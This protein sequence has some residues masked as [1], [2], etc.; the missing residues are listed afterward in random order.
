MA[1]ILTSDLKRQ[2]QTD[3]LNQIIGNDTD[4]LTSAI[5]TAESELKSYLIQ[6]YL[7]ANEFE[8]YELY[9]NPATYLAGAR[10]YLD[11]STYNIATTYAVGDLVLYSGNVYR[12][13]SATPGVFDPIDWTLLGEQYS[14]FYTILPPDYTYFNY[15]TVYAVGDKVVYLNYKYTAI[16]P[17]EGLSSE[18]A[19]QYQRYS[20]LPYYNVFPNDTVNGLAYWGTGVA[21]SYVNQSVTNT[22][23]FASGDNRNQELVMY[24]ID[25]AL[26]HLHSRIAPRNIPELRVKRYD[27]A[28]SKLKNYAKGDDVTLDLPRI[29]PN[30]GAR[31][32]YNSNVKLIN[33]Y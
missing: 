3:N 33:T 10:V 29:Q 6:K 14:K 21:L 2:I 23:V 4:L 17:S 30:S 1:Y 9:A 7:I 18:Q 27:D 16:K 22:A 19:I 31:I 11:A 8:G 12:N 24:C 15:L 20:D 28:I 5:A 13:L 25:I 26:Y 32:R